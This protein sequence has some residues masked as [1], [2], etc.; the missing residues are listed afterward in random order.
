MIISEKVIEPVDIYNFM[1]FTL[2]K[3]KFTVF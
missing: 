1:F 3:E 2:D